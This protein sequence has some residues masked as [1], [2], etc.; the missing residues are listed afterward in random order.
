MHS[1]CYCSLPV[2]RRSFL[3]KGIHSYLF[4][5]HPGSALGGSGR[6]TTTLVRDHEYFIHATFHQNP[7]SSSGEEVENVKVYGRRTTTTGDGRTDG[8][9]D[10]GLCAM[11]IAHLRLRL[12]WAKKEEREGIGI[13][14]ISAELLKADAT[15][16][17]N[18]RHDIFLSICDMGYRWGPPWLEVIII[19]A[20]KER[21]S[22]F[23]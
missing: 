13:D 3:K 2:W 18:M 23:V 9:T 15:V 6:K 17:V 21:T 7:L 20:S 5:P 19:K 1:V 11:T 14:N 4:L 22:N 12:R 16:A 8:R 10:D